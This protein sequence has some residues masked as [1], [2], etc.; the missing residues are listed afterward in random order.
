LLQ[1][2]VGHQFLRLRALAGAWCSKKNDSHKYT[3]VCF[4]SCR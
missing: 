1:T 3:S 4:M 2:I